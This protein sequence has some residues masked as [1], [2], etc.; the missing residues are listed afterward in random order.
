MCITVGT[1]KGRISREFSS[2]HQSNY[3]AVQDN[4]W[5]DKDTFNDWIEKV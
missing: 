4:A 1:K 2:Y 5:V 3:Y